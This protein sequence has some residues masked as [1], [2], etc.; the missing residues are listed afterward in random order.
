METSFR[1][2]SM[3]SRAVKTISLDRAC[4]GEV[5]YNNKEYILLAKANSVAAL[6]IDISS[7]NVLHYLGQIV[8]TVSG[9]FE[10]I[11]PQKQFTY[12]FP[13]NSLV[14]CHLPS[15]AVVGTYL[16]SFLVDHNG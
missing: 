14:P 10:W 11:A 6:Q 12:L 2:R 13:D 4:F 15:H 3:S 7:R 5:S 16:Q 8:L 9:S 1:T